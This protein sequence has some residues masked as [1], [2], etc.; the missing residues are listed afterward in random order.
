MGLAASLAASRPAATVPDQLVGAAFRDPETFSPDPMR[1]IHHKR[2]AQVW[3]L[4]QL[5]GVV[6]TKQA[7]QGVT[8]AG[9]ER[10]V[11]ARVNPS[12]VPQ[13]VDFREPWAEEHWH[14]PKAFPVG[15]GVV[16]ALA[17][18]FAG[19]LA[20]TGAIRAVAARCLELNAERDV[21][22]GPPGAITRNGD[23]IDAHALAGWM[24]APDLR[25]QVEVMRELLE[26]DLGE[27]GLGGKRHATGKV[28]AEEYPLKRCNGPVTVGVTA[29]PLA[30]TGL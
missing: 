1:G 21:W 6:L 15:P 2:P 30:G 7:G 9:P 8:S 5:S 23:G 11:G 26:D 3:R 25:G 10:L 20:L 17:D 24:G 22:P 29:K 4:D 14:P 18:D 27:P 13:V 28:E 12:G 16:D 19:I